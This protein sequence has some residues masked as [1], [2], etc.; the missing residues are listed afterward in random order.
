[1]RIS[2]SVLVLASAAYFG[3]QFSA[4]AQAFVF[5][6]PVGMAGANGSRDAT[7]SAAR[8][9]APGD[10]AVDGAGNLYVADTDNHVIRRVAPV[11]N[12]WVVT[13]LAGTAGNTGTRDGT[14]GVAQF[15]Y[16][17]AIAVDSQ[18]N[19]YVADTDNHTIRKIR[20]IGTN[21]VVTTLAGT[22]G[23]HGTNDGPGYSASFW[24]P[25]GVAVDALGNVFVADTY[26]QTIRMLVP[27]GTNCAVS[28]LAGLQ[29]TIG[30][31]DG[32]NSVARFD[33]PAGIAVGAGTNLYVADNG[34]CTIRRVTPL[35]GNWVVTTLA[36]FAEDPNWQDGT[37]SGALFNFPYS[38]A[39]DA[40]T[41]LYVADTYND[42]IRKIT[43]IGTNWV[44]STVGG[45]PL[46]PSGS[47]DGVGTAALFTSP[48]GIT[49]DRFGNLYVA[50][51]AN[52]TIRLGQVGFSLQAALV[53]GQLVLSWPA[54][55][56]NYVLEAKSPLTSGSWTQITSG[57]VL[58]GNSFF[59]TNSVA[60][61]SG[62]Y[63]LHLGQAGF[64][65]QA[66]L[67]GGQLVLSWPAAASDY[68][69]ETK[70]LLAPGSWTQITNGIVL[71]GN[72]FFKTNSVAG[73]SGF[74]RL[75]K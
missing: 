44:V 33:Y 71:S 9:S 72:S 5:T 48:Q 13:T 57:I 56:S 34:N 61:L 19:L 12:N 6:T 29:L 31:A 67:V 58:S 32:S 14:N 2:V 22:P 74:F 30:I 7:N 47:V 73:L 23:N 26:N 54:A 55:A 49:V 10:I 18:T 38:V 52:N 40:K 43:P 70:G 11:G 69:L 21:W 20:P 66:A 8:F 42:A 60:G 50:D 28:T 37:N 68:V 17:S 64:S 53:K 36:G 41:N 45:A 39:V 65:L 4:D 15:L 62:F 46:L 27:V 1:M 63:R 59:K 35:A 75:R 51:T 16:P 24:Y 25:S 3:P